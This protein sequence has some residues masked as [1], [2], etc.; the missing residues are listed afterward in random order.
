MTVFRES[1]TCSPWTTPELARACAKGLDPAYDLT[2]AIDFV[3]EILFRLSGRQFP[4]VCSQTVWPCQGEGCGR[5]EDAGWSAHGASTWHYASGGGSSGPSTPYPTGA[6]GWVNCWDC[7][8]GVG[9]GSCA[10]GCNIPWLTL[11]GPVISVE[12]VVV[13]GLVVPPE[14]YVIEGGR[15]LGRQDG[16]S[17]PCS[18]NLHNT[19]VFLDGLYSVIVSGDNGS[20]TLNVSVDGV[21]VPFLVDVADSASVVQGLLVAE[22]G[23]DTF[24]VTGGPANAVGDAP[25]VIT[26][27]TELL[28]PPVVLSAVFPNLAIGV[29]P[30]GVVVSTVTA[31]TAPGSGAWYV[32]YSYGKRIP[33][34]GRFAAAVFAVQVAL[35][36]CG[37]TECTLPARLKDIAREGVQ[38]AFAD[39]LEFIGKGE[40]GIYEVDLWLN[41][42]NPKKI[43]RRASVYRADVVKPPRRF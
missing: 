18:N 21:T 10:G 22:Y 15:R 40:V 20:W 29:D 14:A 16:G 3:S 42:V 1:V 30:G 17:W 31:G 33:P 24:T 23:V 11:P 25:F 7:G 5:S 13:G 28:A 12:Q 41:S 43:Q 27:N 9:G 38:M 34:G 39:P 35:A 4:G 32:T 6:G 2:Q 36:R 37:S 19:T 8:Q 26:A